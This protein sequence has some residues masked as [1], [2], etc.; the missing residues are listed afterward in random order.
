MKA[1]IILKSRTLNNQ[2]F[3]CISYLL[4]IESLN[5]GRFHLDRPLSQQIQVDLNFSS[6]MVDRL[7][8]LHEPAQVLDVGL[9]QNLWWKDYRS[10]TN[11]P[12]KK[13]DCNVSFPMTKTNNN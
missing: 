5:G 2:N 10:M 7:L 12:L 6:V 4:Q 3:N 13:R 1:H 9:Q 8:L 11:L